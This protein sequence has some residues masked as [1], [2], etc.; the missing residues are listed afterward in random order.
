MP[1]TLQLS[2][3]RG[4]AFILVIVLLVVLFVIAMGF[5]GITRIDRM[6]SQL[7]LRDSQMHAE[8]NAA[9]EQVVGLL[10]Q[11]LWGDDANMLGNGTSSHDVADEPFDV[12][13]TNSDPAKFGLWDD[14]WLASTLPETVGAD[15]R[16]PHVTNLAGT[17]FG[18]SVAASD[19]NVLASTLEADADRDGI[20]DSRWYLSPSG[21]FRIAVRVVDECSMMNLNT[22]GRGFADDRGSTPSHIAMV[23]WNAETQWNNGSAP[24][25]AYLV[26][27]QHWSGSNPES[28]NNAYFFGRR[29][30]GSNADG[31]T[32]T[33]AACD[34][35]MKLDNPRLLDV[36]PDALPFRPWET[37]A[38]QSYGIKAGPCAARIDAGWF[39]SMKTTR[40]TM[41]D[42]RTNMTDPTWGTGVNGNWSY[43]MYYT[44]YNWVR[45]V[46][47]SVMP[48]GGAPS[49]AAS[50]DAWMAIYKAG[51]KT[52][53]DPGCL[54]V[55]NASPHNA[56]YTK[57]LVAAFAL[58]GA[59][60]PTGGLSSQQVEQAVVNLA[61]WR[62]ADQDLSTTGAGGGSNKVDTVYNTSGIYGNEPQVF[63]T[64]VAIK[65]YALSTWSNSRYALELFNPYNVD[66]NVGYW[67]IR[68]GTLAVTIPGGTVVSAGGRLTIRS[69][70]TTAEGF[71]WPSVF[72]GTAITNGNLLFRNGDINRDIELLRPMLSN[73]ASGA[74]NPLVIVD[75]AGN[76][77]ISA[78]MGVS[79]WL[80]RPSIGNVTRHA[81]RGD[82]QWLQSRDVWYNTPTQSFGSQNAEVVTTFYT[83][84]QDGRLASIAVPPDN[85]VHDFDTVG[86]LHYLMTVG[87]QA[88]GVSGCKAVTD[89]IT[90]ATTGA[91][92]GDLYLNWANATRGDY[93][94][95]GWLT[96]MSR[97]YN[98]AD[99]NGDGTADDLTELRLPG[100]VNVNT[101]PPHVIAQLNW[102]LSPRES[103][104]S[105]TNGYVY[106]YEWQRHE[107]GKPAASAFIYNQ[108]IYDQARASGF[109]EGVGELG[110]VSELMD[111]SAVLNASQFARRPNGSP[112]ACPF[113]ARN[114]QREME[115]YYDEYY[116]N[117]LPPTDYY[118]YAQVAPGNPN[119]RHFLLDR[120][121]DVATTRSDTFLVYV[122]IQDLNV[123]YS[124]NYWDAAAGGPHTQRLVALIDRSRCNYPPGNASH[125]QPTIVLRSQP[126]W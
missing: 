16:W 37:L 8:A 21:R 26:S 72:I 103:W 89:H 65:H 45:N 90:A 6:A 9:I 19:T 79:Q 25:D 62:D 46:H 123:G 101:A 93:R 66:V 47:P 126:T 70:A 40:G 54:Y 43:R 61:D 24:D 44:T 122:L 67:Q 28:M 11:D 59:M 12:P 82:K 120:I 60:A 41:P 71:G 68:L 118:F 36:V 15:Y 69:H 92:T 52:A 22:G 80:D 78:A 58:S 73:Q 95:L 108:K 77:A 48:T 116:M 31:R 121:T 34:Y 102:Q 29:S 94:V 75:R 51:L 53:D 97:R 27:A 2:R 107:Q 3:R 85:V 81:S 20:N 124:G 7:D 17:N 114:I 88:A 50:W 64:E 111:P 105:Q 99:D 117:F 112:G 4:T 115:F 119:E 125:Q 104:N 18:R 76:S 14:A 106:S 100:L 35:S 5:M 57:A 91:A 83:P 42:I 39:W 87:P 86:Q 56:L 74:G 33:D 10:S 1:H 13:C 63:I 55:N 23:R 110:R 113:S 109:T 96:R 32:A 38:M 30:V 84:Y 49:G 98:S